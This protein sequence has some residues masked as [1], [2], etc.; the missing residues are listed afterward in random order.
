M[1]MARRVSLFER[2]VSVRLA[3]VAVELLHGA[4]RVLSEGELA[5]DVYAGSTMLT[6]DLARTADRVS[7]S[8]DASTAQRIAFLYAAD[9][10]CREHARR[11]AMTE[12][13]RT[14]GCDLAA[15]HVD[16][17]SR[18]RGSELLVNLNVEARSKT[19]YRSGELP[20]SADR[21]TP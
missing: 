21:R 7:D 17:E 6:I 20:S 13:R 19:P 5:G 16:V 12:A 9:E 1:A 10:R 3:P 8:P 18:A 15:P 2:E 14:A 11:V 4:A